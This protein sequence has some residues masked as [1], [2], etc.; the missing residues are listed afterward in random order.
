MGPVKKKKG[1]HFLQ[2]IFVCILKT[3]LYSGNLWDFKNID[4]FNDFR[5]LDLVYNTNTMR[6]QSLIFQHVCIQVIFPLVL[7]TNI[8]SEISILLPLDIYPPN[9]S[10]MNI[11]IQIIQLVKTSLQTSLYHTKYIIEFLRDLFLPEK[12]FERVHLV[13]YCQF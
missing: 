13:S 9:L 10:D 2:L 11:A 1:K 3:Y 4:F 5:R 12:L 6:K 8:N 7:F